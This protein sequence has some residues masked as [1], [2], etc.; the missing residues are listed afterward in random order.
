MVE[1]LV[2]AWAERV[3]EELRSLL[4]KAGRTNE[5]FERAYLEAKKKKK[6]ERRAALKIIRKKWG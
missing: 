3:Q 1:T 4:E 2:A 5:E 6:R